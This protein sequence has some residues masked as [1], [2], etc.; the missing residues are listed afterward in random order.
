MD[1][2]KII[3]K[4][5]NTNLVF[6]SNQK[7]FQFKFDGIVNSGVVQN[8][9]IYNE[10]LTPQI[11]GTNNIFTLQYPLISGSEEVKLNGITQTIL[12]DYIVTNSTTIQLVNIPN[13]LDHIL[14]SYNKI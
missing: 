7:I 11:T 13:T 2:H 1:C 3:A 12:D 5:K 14:I 6:K 4:Q 8:Q 9:R 10:N